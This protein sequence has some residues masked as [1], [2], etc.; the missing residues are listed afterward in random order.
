MRFSRMKYH[1]PVMTE[2]VTAFRILHLCFFNAKDEV[3][4][5]LEF[6]FCKLSDKLSG[7]CVEYS[8]CHIQNDTEANLCRL[9][10]EKTKE[11]SKS[12]VADSWVTGLTSLTF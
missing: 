10:M 1:S 5:G 2:A 9:V 4:V 12:T 3:A 7:C 11:G 8:N 6:T